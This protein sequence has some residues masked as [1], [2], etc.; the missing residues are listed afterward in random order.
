MFRREMGVKMCDNTLRNALR[1]QGLSSFTKVKTH[2]LSRKNIKDKFRFAQMHKYWTVNDWERVV[3]S[4]ETKLSC[5]NLDGRTWCWIEDKENIHVRDVN[6]IVKHGG[7]SIML[8]GCL[9]C[10]GLGSLHNIQGHLN[11]RGHIAILKQDLCSTLLA[12]GINLE[13]IIFQQ[14]NF[15]VH[16]TKIVREW[17]G[18]QPIC[19]IEW[20][21]QSPHVTPKGP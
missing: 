3:F 7:G 17:F 4:G 16:T 5:F 18:K 21:T 12:F 13:E 15:V 19:V 20:P 10:R 2:A 14:D 9:T 11:A 6:Q 1:E 8:C